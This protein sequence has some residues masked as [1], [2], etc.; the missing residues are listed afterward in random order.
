MVTLNQSGDGTGTYIA[1]ASR[2]ARTHTKT[3]GDIDGDDC[4]A[5][6]LDDYIALVSREWYTDAE[7]TALVA[8]L[9]AEHGLT[10]GSVVELTSIRAHGP[11]VGVQTTGVSEAVGLEVGDQIERFAREDAP[12]VILL[13]EE[14]VKP[15]VSSDEIFDVASGIVSR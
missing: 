10:L 4:R 2:T 5:G 9:H 1:Q 6:L 13:H 14:G 11:S 12:G 3:D 8:A 15:S 7:W